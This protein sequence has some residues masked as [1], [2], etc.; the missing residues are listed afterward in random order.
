MNKQLQTVMDFIQQNENISAEEK[1]IL[2]KEIKKV[3]SDLEIAVFKLERTENVKRT[4]AILLEETIEE[5]EQKRKAV[6]AQNR[7]LGIESS[8]E[9]V[10]TVAMGMRKPDDM[11]EVCRIISQQS[12]NLGIKEIRNVQT[13]I[14][15]EEKGTY[16]NY[17]YYAKH[18]KL[19]VTEVDYKNHELQS[20][21]ANRMLQG[22]E[23]LFAEALTGKEVLDW[24]EYQKTT[25][26]FADSFLE[27]AQSLNYYFYSLGPVALGIST[28]VPL[29]D[30]EISLFK[31]FRN[32]FDLSYRRFL[33]IEQAEAQTREAQIEVAVERVRAQS[34]AMRQTSDLVNVNTELLNQ[35]TNLQIAGLSGVS[36]YLVDKDEIVTVWDLSSPGN[37]NDPNSYAFKFNSKIHPILG[38]FIGILKSSRQDYFVL[39]FPKERLIQAIEELKAIDIEIANMFINAMESGILQRQWNPSARITGGILSVDLMMPPT[40]DTKTIVLKM[41]GAFNQAYQRFLDLQKA[42]AQA[43]EAQIE[44][45]LER[46]RSRA[47]AM[48][49][50]SEVGD[51][52]DLLFSELEKMDINPTGFSIM[53]FNREQDRYELWRAKEV[54]HQGVYETFSIRAMYDKLDQYLPGFTEELE[55]KWNSGAPFFIAELSGKKRISFIEANRDMGNYTEDQ[56]ENV[57]R[58]YPDPVFWQLIFFKHGW[59]GLIQNEQLPDDDLQVIRRFAD[60]FE[61][62]HTRFLDLQKAE[63]NALRAEEDLIAIKVARQ[64]AEEALA[65][66][67]ATQAQLIQAEKM[68]SLGE[69]T[70]GIAHEIQNP[71]N[72][73][74]NFSEVSVDL[75]D[76]MN[77]EMDTGN[78]DEVKAIMVDLKQN[79]EKIT[80]HGKRASSIV[81]GMLEHSR[82]NSGIKAATDINALADEFLRLAY[83]GLRAKDKSFQSDFKL[84]ADEKLQKVNVVAQD[85]G[86]V[87]LNLINNAFYAVNEKAKQSD[88]NYTPRVIVT[89]KKLGNAIEIRVKDN[90][91]GIP[92]KV[93][94]K[95]FQ[96]FFTTKPTGQGTG[97]GLSMSYEIVTKAHSGELKVDTKEGEGSV[98]TIV[99]PV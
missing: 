47:L 6:E 45:A 79:L 11:L 36:F 87:L 70:A 92:Q 88:E 30:E 95:I 32:V 23:E 98:F 22:A 17:E 78:S 20:L 83:H 56:F 44:A 25:N 34:M 31:R 84:E 46:I 58:I 89:T 53:V 80:H 57:L 67:K 60:V 73:V 40:D 28:Y 15:Y 49:K 19:L 42:E 51:V 38:E 69:L 52:S 61:F 62:A 48:H 81:K 21:F 3:S 24:Y 85:M 12:E 13:A 33:D 18:D 99:L 8:L 16:L 55:S 41:A 96:P 72:F 29:N 35:L 64:K 37:M 2:V 77:Q 9:R 74:N 82:S 1:S 59:L 86:R 4:T 93:L 14:I 76:E 27:N 68:A 75:I 90:G 71:L 66:L 26:Q 7:E 65:E 50:S 43:R 39:D 91:P 10:R 63:A 5:L 54:A 97:L 94:D